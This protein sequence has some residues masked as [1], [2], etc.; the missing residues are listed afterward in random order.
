MA[1]GLRGQ[2]RPWGTASG[3]SIGVQ[4]LEALVRCHGRTWRQ[5]LG[6]RFVTRAPRWP[7]WE[8]ALQTAVQ[9]GRCLCFSQRTLFTRHSSLCIHTPRRA[10][11]VP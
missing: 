3:E 10:S 9:G 2:A 11:H 5:V 1:T 7:G 6:T 4:A 8:G